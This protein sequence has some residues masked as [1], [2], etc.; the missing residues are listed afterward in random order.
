LRFID[1]FKS[2]KWILLGKIVTYKMVAKGC[3]RIETEK[4][5]K[6]SETPR[7][8]KSVNKIKNA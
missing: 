1:D 7:K 3:M 8:L 2:K 6:S 4:K 5:Q